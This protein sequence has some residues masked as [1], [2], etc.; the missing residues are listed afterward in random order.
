MRASETLSWTPFLSWL[1]F[2][3]CILPVTQAALGAVPVFS[4]DGCHM[5]H[6]FVTKTVLLL[7]A[8]DGRNTNMTVCFAVVTSESK[9]DVE[10]FLNHV[11]KAGLADHLNSDGTLFLTDR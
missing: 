1:P 7:C 11:K 6:R 3:V 5:K 2:D 10:Y 4:V 8:R 9:N